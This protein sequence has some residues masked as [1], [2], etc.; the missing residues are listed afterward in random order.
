MLTTQ[1]MAGTLLITTILATTA[2]SNAITFHQS[3]RNSISLELR[4]TDPNQPLQGTIG[5]KNRTIVVAPGKSKVS[6]PGTQATGDA[7]SVVSDFYFSRNKG[8][9]GQFGKTII[10]S[11]FITGDAAREA[12]SQTI[13]SLSGVGIGP[14]QDLTVV[15]A[16]TLGLIVKQLE[17][18]RDDGDSVALGHLAALDKLAEELP[19]NISTQTFY[20]FSGGNLSESTGLQ[21]Q[22]GFKGAMN[23]VDGLRTSLSAISEIESDRSFTQNNNPIS[24]DQ[25]ITLLAAKTRL[26]AERKSFS[27][28]IGNK[29]DIDVAAAYI[30]SKL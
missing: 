11:S 25:M 7:A 28:K 2:C 30:I 24:P 20:N 15:R 8:S 10:R 5:I 23:Y 27:E 26:E 17:I 4:T 9:G 1:R 19:D 3:E 18:L 29:S 21:M 22:S 14:I 16:Q 12:P 6:V 13:E